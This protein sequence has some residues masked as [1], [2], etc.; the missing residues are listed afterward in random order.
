MQKQTLIVA[1][2]FLSSSQI[3]AQIAQRTVIEPPRVV[4]TVKPEITKIE[5]TIDSVVHQGNALINYFKATVYSVGKGTVQFQ[6]VML[7]DQHPG[8]PAPT[9]VYISRSLTLNG[10]GVDEVFHSA[11]TQPNHVTLAMKSIS[12]NIVVSNSA[13]Y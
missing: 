9:P 10:N 8:A 1:V 6:W 12:P 11:V 13:S 3:K 4:S 7:Q 5:L 2:V